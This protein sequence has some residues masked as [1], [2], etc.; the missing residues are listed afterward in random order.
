MGVLPKHGTTDEIGMA[1]TDVR[2]L[3]EVWVAL[4]RDA[5]DEALERA[6]EALG[7]LDQLEG[8]L[9]ELCK[10]NSEVAAA[11][12]T[13]K[14]LRETDRGYSRYHIQ[15]VATTRE[16]AISMCRDETYLIGPLPVNVALPH[17]RTEWPGLHFPLKGERE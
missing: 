16:I 11:L 2:N 14:S 13:L 3:T 8:Y 5:G 17:D 4:R 6:Q 7:I 9:A 10:T 12:E 15:G 1:Y